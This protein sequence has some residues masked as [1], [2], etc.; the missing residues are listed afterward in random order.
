M[1]RDL[2]FS[3]LQVLQKQLCEMVNGQENLTDPAVVALSEE[4]DRLIVELQRNRMKE[5]ARYRAAAGQS[6]RFAGSQPPEKIREQRGAII[7]KQP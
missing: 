4:A 5:S 6:E 3:R 1:D 2:L 7:L